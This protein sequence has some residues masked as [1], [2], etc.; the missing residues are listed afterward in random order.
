VQENLIFPGQMLGWMNNKPRRKGSVKALRP[1]TQDAKA[2]FQLVLPAKSPEHLKARSPAP[3]AYGRVVF[4]DRLKVRASAQALTGLSAKRVS[5]PDIL[6][7]EEMQKMISA[8][9]LRERVLVFPRE[10][11]GS[12]W[13]DIDFLNL[14]IDV[15][16]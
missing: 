9:L 10:L 6:T 12:K 15:S 1:Q 8:V 11:A 13:A 7:V 3:T 5:I 2:R 16:R 14:Q 4:R